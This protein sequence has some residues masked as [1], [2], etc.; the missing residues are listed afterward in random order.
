MPAEGKGRFFSLY[1]KVEP[2]TIGFRVIIESHCEEIQMRVNLFFL[3]I[4]FHELVVA[5]HSE[6]DIGGLK[7]IGKL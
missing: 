5:S 4:F 7:I 1:F 2:L 3:F 6:V